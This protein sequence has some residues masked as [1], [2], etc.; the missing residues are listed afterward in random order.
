MLIFGED[1]AELVT[2]L[3][4]YEA[5]AQEKWLERFQL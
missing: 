2:A 1:P 3:A 5:P 4:A